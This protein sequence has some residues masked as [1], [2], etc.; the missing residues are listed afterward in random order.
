M[1]AALLSLQPQA[2][3]SSPFAGEPLGVAREDADDRRLAVHR[4]IGAHGYQVI[5]DLLGNDVEECIA[6]G[7]R[8]AAVESLQILIDLGAGE[9]QVNELLEKLGKEAA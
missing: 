2:W 5:V 3:P 7:A 1:R 8:D 6:N 9:Q 4:L